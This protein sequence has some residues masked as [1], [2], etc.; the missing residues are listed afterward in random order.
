MLRSLQKGSIV[1]P[2]IGGTSGE[3]NCVDWS[4][5][6]VVASSWYPFSSK[7]PTGMPKLVPPLRVRLEPGSHPKT[8]FSSDIAGI[9]D[10]N[11][12]QSTDR[13]Y[14]HD[15]RRRRGRI[16][17]G[18]HRRLWWTVRIKTGTCSFSLGEALSWNG[19]DWICLVQGNNV[20]LASCPLWW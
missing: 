6:D 5:R 4:N 15:K 12:P 2:E 14:I 9:S 7:Q 16:E 19:P 13:T 10:Y 8:V 17:R 18:H 3:L 1:L 11:G 20:R